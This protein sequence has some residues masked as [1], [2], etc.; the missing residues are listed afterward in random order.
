MVTENTRRHFEKFI[1]RERQ[2]EGRN[3]MYGDTHRKR[4]VRKWGGC[5]ERKREKERERERERSRGRQTDRQSVR[6]TDR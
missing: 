5:A 2:V 6:Q 3:I 1:L 4:R